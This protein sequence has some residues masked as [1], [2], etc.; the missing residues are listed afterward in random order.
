MQFETEIHL[1]EPWFR[2]LP[3]AIE[4]PVRFDL[5]MDNMFPHSCLP[6]AYSSSRDGLSRVWFVYDSL[7]PSEFDRCRWVSPKSVQPGKVSGPPTTRNPSYA[8]AR[9]FRAARYPRSSYQRA[10][11]VCRRFLSRIK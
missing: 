11:A 8:V 4:L 1:V 9:Q 7:T 3:A 2:D 6:L 5:N 10:I